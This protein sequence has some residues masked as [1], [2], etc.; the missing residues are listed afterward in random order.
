VSYSDPLPQSGSPWAR[1]GGGCPRLA[2]LPICLVDIS[3][4]A[5]VQVVLNVAG[6][7]CI[8]TMIVSVGMPWCPGGC[9]SLG[10]R[11]L[12]PRSTPPF[13]L[14]FPRP[15]GNRFRSGCPVFVL[16][17]ATAFSSTA[18]NKGPRK[19]PPFFSRPRVFNSLVSVRNFSN[20]PIG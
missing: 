7:C 13:S 6:Y 18:P 17:L 11:R 19:W 20:H 14:S 2:L 15:S 4:L 5:R 3:A 12:N 16:L 9:S 10:T 1:G 8:A